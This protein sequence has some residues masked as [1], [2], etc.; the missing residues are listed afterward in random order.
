MLAEPR[1]WP[2]STREA[3]P[4]AGSSSH[5]AAPAMRIAVSPSARAW[6]IRQTSALPPPGIRGITSIRHSGRERSRCWAKM[7]DTVARNPASSA[8]A[9]SAGL[10]DLRSDVHLRVRNPPRRAVDLGQ[11]HAQLRR[12][13]QALGDGSP[14]PV[15]V[16]RPV[17]LDDLARVPGH[18]LVLQRQ[19]A[20]ALGRQAP[21]A[22]SLRWPPISRHDRCTPHAEP[23]AVDRSEHVTLCPN[24]L[25]NHLPDG[26]GRQEGGLGAGAGT[27]GSW[28]A[29]R[30]GEPRAAGGR[31]RGVRAEVGRG[32]AGEPG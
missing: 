31:V 27:A 22:R 24:T 32:T 2:G 20:L 19:D 23:H 4:C 21:R 15:D 17:Q 26:P 25:S 28:A 1:P 18:G 5:S 29:G 10:H 12:A 30:S 3:A 13:R 14:Q 8:A 11:A 9:D 7:A 6:W 16:E